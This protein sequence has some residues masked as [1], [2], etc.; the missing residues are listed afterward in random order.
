M[1]SSNV[2]VN[3]EGTTS[4]QIFA[5]VVNF[6]KKEE[7]P[8]SSVEGQLALRMNYRGR[9]G[10][11]TCS[12]EFLDDRNYLLFYSFHPVNVPE[13]KRLAVAEFLTRANYR[14]IFGNFEMDFIY[15]EVS[16]RTSLNV[17]GINLEFAQISR[18]VYTNVATMDKYVPGIMQ[19]IY[20][21]VSAAEAIAQIEGHNQVADESN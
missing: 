5:E 10:R 9:N 8:Y 13:H 11:L 21:D 2:I 15:G 14:I 3:Q 7:W 18:L 16:Y 19:I 12:F 6:F 4:S 1:D 20:S 17:E